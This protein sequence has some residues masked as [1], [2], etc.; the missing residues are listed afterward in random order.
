MVMVLISMV[1]CSEVYIR[2]LSSIV[3][4]M[5]RVCILMFFVL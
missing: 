4:N 5:L 3:V 1:V 2:C